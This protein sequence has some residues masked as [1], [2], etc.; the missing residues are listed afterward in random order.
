M[1]PRAVHYFTDQFD[2]V[3]LFTNIKTSLCPNCKMYL[4][5]FLNVFVQISKC[6]CPDC[7]QLCKCFLIFLLTTCCLPACT[8]FATF[9]INVAT[10]YATH[11]SWWQLLTTK[12]LANKIL[13]FIFEFV[14][15]LWV[16]SS[17]RPLSR[18]GTSTTLN[19]QQMWRHM[20]SSVT[21]IN[22]QN[23]SSC[24]SMEIYQ[25]CSN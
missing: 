9:S 22:R 10:F 21:I 12:T 20:W 6:I 3:Y 17:Y 4:S 14:I 5:K 2:S 1:Q 11:V 16:L 18:T 23:N 25:K 15:H 13:T 8:P 19:V 7:W 24:L